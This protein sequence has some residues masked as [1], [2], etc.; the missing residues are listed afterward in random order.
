MAAERPALKV[1]VG[2]DEAGRVPDREGEAQFTPV[3]LTVEMPDGGASSR[4]PADIAIA[5]D[6]SGSMGNEAKIKS[7]DGLETSDGLTFLDIAKHAMRTVIATLDEHD[8]LAIAAFDHEARDILHLTKMDA[9]GRRMATQKVDELRE[10]G[11]TVIWGGLQ[12]AMELLKEGKEEGG[13]VGHVM[14]L[15]DGQTQYRDRLLPSLEEY[16]K[17][18]PTEGLPGSLSTFGFGYDIDSEILVQIADFGGGA[19]SF[20]PDAGMVGTVFIN[21]L[22]NGLATH[23]TDASVSA[24]FDP[25]WEV[26]AVAGSLKHTKTVDDGGETTVRVNLGSLQYGQNRSALIMAAPTS[27]PKTLVAKLDYRVAGRKERLEGDAVEGSSS[28]KAAPE[29][30]EPEVLRCEFIETVRDNLARMKN[31]AYL[32][33][34]MARIT[35]LGA[36]IGRSSAPGHPLVKGLHEDVCGQTS[37]AFSRLDWYLKWGC[38]YMPSIMFAH[39]MQ[40]CNNFKDPSV[41]V[42]GGKLFHD[43]QEKADVVFNEIPPPQPRPRQTCGTYASAAPAAPAAPVNM[44]NYNDRY[45]VCIDAG[46]C[47]LLADGAGARRVGELQKGDRVA[48]PDG[49][50]A[51]VVCVVRT[52]CLGGR[53]ALVELAPG[54]RVTPFH[55]VFMSGAWTFPA[56]I[57]EPQE[58]ACDAVCSLLLSG[59]PAVLLGDAGAG[60]QGQVPAAALGHGLDE[61]AARHEYFGSRAVVDDVRSAPGFLAGRVEVEPHHV[62]R[63]PATGLVQAFRF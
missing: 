47:A 14:L 40:Q 30:V 29:Y 5:I 9:E 11:A 59:A 50:V 45:G 55:P 51:E 20:I 52:K 39:R 2:A 44:S 8:R 54:V 41:Q 1:H 3:V 35:D 53:A 57:A 37:E 60:S 10:R 6:I 61:G 32:E 25:G 16:A 13:R 12:L 15:T 48:A 49:G 24:T 43:L 46:S 17:N 19:Y 34:A 26:L 36:R 7:A 63:D 27:E 4:A 18:S 33:Q 38:H 22:A 62:V 31:T 28:S 21:T 42:Y 56:D 23:A 58:R